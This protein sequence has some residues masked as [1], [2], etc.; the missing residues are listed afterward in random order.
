MKSYALHAACDRH[1]RRSRPL[2][3]QDQIIPDLTGTAGPMTLP[4]TRQASVRGP[5][6][7]SNREH[8][9]LPR[10]P[11]SRLR[12]GTNAGNHVCYGRPGD[13]AGCPL[14]MRGA[15]AQP[16]RSQS[17]D[18]SG[19]SN[20]T[21]CAA[22]A[23]P[24]PLARWSVPV[25]TGRSRPGPVSRIRTARR[26]PVTRQ[27][28]PRGALVAAVVALLGRR[29][30]SLSVRDARSPSQARSSEGAQRDEAHRRGRH[31]R[32]AAGQPR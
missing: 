17:P 15:V 11:P 25:E 10:R 6:A 27:A 18:S 22:L 2:S 29:L 12:A 28:P 14:T 26:G 20:S 13:A 3:S 4:A 23:R 5:P 19:P 30:G 1:R 31:H 7:M 32:P 8:P 24:A 16:D 9:G 21:W